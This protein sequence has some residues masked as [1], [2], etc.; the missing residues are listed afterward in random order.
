MTET[1]PDDRNLPVV[2]TELVTR[3]IDLLC[4]LTRQT[5]VDHATRF[6]C[7]DPDLVEGRMNWAATES[8]ATGL[9]QCTGLA[10]HAQVEPAEMPNAAV[11]KRGHGQISSAGEE[12]RP[13]PGSAFLLPAERPS[14]LLVGAVAM[15]T[16]QV[17]WTAVG[18]L[19]EERTGMP[20]ADLRFAAMAPVSAAQAAAFGRTVDFLCDELITTALTEIEPLLA[21][22]LTRLAAT[23][24]LETFPNTAMTLSYRP[25]PGWVASGTVSR[26][27]E[28]IDAHAGQPITVAEVAE[29][30][31]VTVFAL[32]YSFQHHLGLTPEQ[33]LRRVRLERAR[34]DLASPHPACGMTAAGVSRR[35][36]WVSLSQFNR[37]CLRRFGKLPGLTS[38]N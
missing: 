11:I 1:R 23:A 22:E 33:Y 20:A 38:R 15:A 17:P 19:A 14:A 2:Q 4:E 37:A 29:S 25:G 3:D 6:H 35:W 27:A 5:Y 34:Q 7:A 24:M 30:A 18:A 8:V 21:Q 16:L 9:L 32:R 10:C 31:Q 26:A 28:F 36:G 13:G 12:L